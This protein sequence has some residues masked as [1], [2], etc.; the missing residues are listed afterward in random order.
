MEY[1]ACE[2]CNNGTRGSDAVAALMARLHPDN[3]EGSWRADEIRTLK[4]AIDAHAPGVRE[5]MSLIDAMIPNASGS[6]NLTGW[7]HGSS[8]LLVARQ[9]QGRRPRGVHPPSRQASG[10]RDPRT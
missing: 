8:N 9:F 2:A 3:G 6:I 5:E 7:S 1:G 4:S 10:R